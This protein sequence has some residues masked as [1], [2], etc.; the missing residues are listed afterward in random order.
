MKISTKGRYGLRALT[1]LAAHIEGEPISLASV[2]KRQNLSLNYLEQVFGTLRRAGIV[3]SMKGPQGG[4]LL[5][6]EA[7]K[8][9]VKEILEA[10]EG[11]FSIVDS[12][13]QPEEMDAVEKAIQE[14]VWDQID[15]RINELLSS[16]TLMQLVEEYRQMK[17]GQEPMYYI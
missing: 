17:E 15:D 11:R 14:L 1:D 13:K 8:I 9:T 6:R 10:L 16:R 12:G 3:K 4:Y 2:A 7:S 5:M